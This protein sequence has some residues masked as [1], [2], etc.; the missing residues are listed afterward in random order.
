MR[1]AVNRNA[2]DSVATVLSI[3][4]SPPVLAFAIAL[5]VAL[6]TAGRPTVLPSVAELLLAACVLPTVSTLALFRAG[7]TSTLDLRDRSERAIPSAITA[8]C[9]SLGYVFMR[10]SG[11]APDV[12]NLAIALAAQMAALAI[13]TTRWKVSYHA[14]TA[15][16]LVAVSRPLDNGSLTLSLVVLACSIGWARVYLGRH[17]LNQVVIGA[18]T[19]LP[20]SVLA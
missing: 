9:C 10:L 16:A 13:L 6:R 3:V 19:T 15:A 17:T 5:L 20:I 1:A 18:L 7:V 14:A 2:F 12:A 8:L 4:G 11:A